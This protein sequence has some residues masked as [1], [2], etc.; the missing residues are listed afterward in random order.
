[1]VIVTVYLVLYANLL[2]G[3]NVA[4][5]PLVLTEPLTLLPPPL[6]LKV[7]VV[8]VEPFIVSLKVAVTVVFIDIPVAP[9]DGLVELTVNVTPPPPPPPPLSPPPPPPPPAVDQFVLLP[10]SVQLTTEIL[11]LLKLL[12]SFTSTKLTDH[13]PC[14]FILH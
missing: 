12:E 1:V 6:T 4:L 10:L 5:L 14:G 9:L 2:E 13:V 7:S 11:V 3:V 8:R